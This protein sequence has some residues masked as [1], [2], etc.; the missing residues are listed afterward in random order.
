MTTD[1]ATPGSPLPVNPETKGFT[2]FGMPIHRQIVTGQRRIAWSATFILSLVWFTFGFHIFAG[3][4]ALTFTL[5]RYTNDPRILAFVKSIPAF[6]VLGPFISYISDRVWT[7]LGR[8]RPFLIIAWAAS[9]V[10]MFCIAFLPQVAGAINSF[11][12]SMGIAPVAEVILLV[13]IVA[14][15]TTLGDLQAPL[16]PLFLECV[17]PHQRGRFFAIRGI[18]F[19]LAVLFFFQVL[20][21]VY[22]HP[23]N[24]WGWWV[25]HPELGVLRGEQLIYI[26]AGTLFFLT[27]G[28]LLFNI[29]ETIDPKSPNKRLLEVLLSSNANAVQEELDSAATDAAQGPAVSTASATRTSGIWFFLPVLFLFGYLVDFTWLFTTGSSIL[30]HFTLS[31]PQSL[32]DSVKGPANSP[33]VLWHILFS[34]NRF[35]DEVR[36]GASNPGKLWLIFHAPLLGTALVAVILVFM[37]HRLAPALMIILLGASAGAYLVLW[38]VYQMFYQYMLEMKDTPASLAIL[39]FIIS[40]AGAVVAIWYLIRS[41]WV[42]QTFRVDPLD[43]VLRIPIIGFFTRYLMD[44]FFSWGNYAFYIVLVI[45]GIEQAVWGDF[46]NIM[47][48]DQFGYSKA[49]QALWGFP[50]QIFTMLALTPFAGWYADTRKI[51]NHWARHA[52]LV[53]AMIL[54]GCAWLYYD[55]YAPADPRQLP[56]I[57]LRS[58]PQWLA[59]LSPS[60]LDVLIT[61]YGPV[62]VVGALM[63]FGCMSL[64]VWIVETMLSFTGREHTKAWVTLLALVLQLSVNICLYTGIQTAHDKVIPITLWMML[65]MANG[66]FG[67]LLGTFIGPMIYEYMPRSR[68]GTINAGRGLMGAWLQAAVMIVGAY[69]ITWY[70]NRTLYPDGIIPKDRKYDYTGIYLIQFILFIPTILATL[71]FLW[72][73][74]KGKIKKWGVLEVEGDSV[75]D[76]HTAPTPEDKRLLG[77]T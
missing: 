45:P 41:K 37:R 4:L 70:S 17:P 26:F 53:V 66:A 29:R 55:N 32:L 42:R 22:D 2:I 38:P 51:I 13:A 3:G 35:F 9:S 1:P 28:F 44:V 59:N 21:P 50:M 77:E 65:N 43:T 36:V 8:R 18:L 31:I 54:L 56:S 5:Q 16:E 7:P 19:S 24:W 30:K 60:W 52:L 15:Y 14:G 64:F 27:G 33:T 62:F 40:L 49:N 73:I 57:T 68:M 63:S 23:V 34:I 72:M 10:A 20:W 71:W 67:A 11:L 39:R 46:G 76:G 48:N 74:M 25:G 6:I 69:W 12:T 58:L 61:E 75:A 47:Q